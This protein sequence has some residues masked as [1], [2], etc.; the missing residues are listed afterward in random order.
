MNDNKDKLLNDIKKLLIEQGQ[1]CI[2]NEDGS[3]CFQCDG[4]AIGKVLKLFK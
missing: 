2:I 4:C 1:L 3:Y